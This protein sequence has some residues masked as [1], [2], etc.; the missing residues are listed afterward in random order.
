MSRSTPTWP[1]NSI[2]F[3]RRRF[4][5]A[6]VATLPVA[7]AATLGS[8]LLPLSAARAQQAAAEITTADLGGGLTLLQGSG[9]NVIAMRGDDGA[10]MIDGGLAAQAAALLRAV[11]DV[12][13]ND[14][15]HT[16]I[17][18]HWHR[19]QT[20]A[21]EAV[22]RAGGVIFAHEN[23]RLFLSEKV[24]SM[25]PEGRLEPITPLPEVAR[26]QRITRGDGALEFAGTQI[27][28]GYLPQAH[29]DGDLYVHFADMNVLAAGGV[30]SGEQ[31]PLLDYR[32]GAWFGGRVRALEWLAELVEP[33]TQV[34]PAQGRSITGRDVVRQRD[35]YQ[36][37]FETM[38]GY[39]N[40][41]FGAEDA[42]A[43]NP[44]ER[45]QAEFG[46]PSAFLDGAYRSMLIAYV[47]E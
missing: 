27:N 4:L 45:Y 40:L 5:R 26:P 34:V 32:N 37:L 20:G 9:C 15:I 28:F 11:Q 43:S 33:D 3:S 41:G 35:I 10:L 2:R 18:T 6:A 24:Y 12:T 8:P 29:T 46:D 31:W 42:V 21:N 16:L 25:T 44:L 13:G 22:G 7:G 1:I 39:M 19:E 36:E 14:R 17:N 38:I 47:P 23:T 30:V